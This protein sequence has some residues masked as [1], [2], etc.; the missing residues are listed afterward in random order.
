[1][2]SR[3]SESPAFE[4]ALLLENAATTFQPIL[5]QPEWQVKPTHTKRRKLKKLTESRFSEQVPNFI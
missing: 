4:T 5:D 3:L 1:V 2:V